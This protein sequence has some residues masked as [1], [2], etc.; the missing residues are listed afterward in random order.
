MSIREEIDYS[1]VRQGPTWTLTPNSKEKTLEIIVEPAPDGK[2]YFDA[3]YRDNWM[4][5]DLSALKGLIAKI[6]NSHG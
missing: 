6:E 4:S 2:F 3:P 1:G 5:I